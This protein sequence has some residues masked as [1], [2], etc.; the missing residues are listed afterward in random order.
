[1]PSESEPKSKFPIVPVL[2]IGFVILVVLGG[3]L[4]IPNPLGYPVNMLLPISQQD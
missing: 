2:I 4:L 1:M 3:L